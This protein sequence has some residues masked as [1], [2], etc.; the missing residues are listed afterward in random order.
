MPEMSVV[1]F[2]ESDVIVASSIIF[3]NFEDG[4]ATNGTI[5]KG[6]TTVYY[7]GHN[8]SFVDRINEFFPGATNVIPDG[9]TS[10]TDRLSLESLLNDDTGAIPAPRYDGEYTWNAST[11]EFTHQ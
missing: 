7:G 6:S 11:G 4:I 9:S 1:R 10:Y 3:S 8:G 5:T 2:N